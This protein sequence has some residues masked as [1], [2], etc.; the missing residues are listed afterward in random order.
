MR[1]KMITLCPTTY[2]YAR[3]MPNF[4][5]W[6][7]MKVMEEY[8]IVANESTIQAKKEI[9]CPNCGNTKGD[10]YCKPLQMFVKGVSE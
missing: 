8:V 2:E 9:E 1:N 4:S 5:S 6:V 3:K 10:H 7:R